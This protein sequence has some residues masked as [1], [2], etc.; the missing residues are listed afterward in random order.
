VTVKSKRGAIGSRK[1]GSDGGD[2]AKHPIQL[3]IEKLYAAGKTPRIRVDARRNDVVIPEH[4]RERWQDSLVIDLDPGY[5]LNLVYA[6][7][8]VHVDLAF[9]GHQSRCRFGWPAI[10]G[11]FDRASGQG[12][13]I[14]AHLPLAE[15]PEELRMPTTT[16]KP[17]LRAI[18]TASR[19]VAPPAPPDKSEKA[20]STDASDEAAKARRAKFRVITGG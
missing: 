17:K 3:G 9:A 8:G 7:D 15:L 1:G 6:D 10:Y 14:A 11:L 2:G 18:S 19:E 13:Q 20:E 5:P 16:Q 4:V 12:V